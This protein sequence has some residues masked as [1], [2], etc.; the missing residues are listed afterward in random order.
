MRARDK[1]GAFARPLTWHPVPRGYAHPSFPEARVQSLAVG[2]PPLTH[3]S[4][5]RAS[6][7]SAYQYSENWCR[8]TKRVLTLK[9]SFCWFTLILLHGSRELWHCQVSHRSKTLFIGAVPLC[10]SHFGNAYGYF[11]F[12][13]V[14]M[15]G[16][17]YWL[18]MGMGWV[19]DVL[20]SWVYLQIMAVPHPVWLVLLVIHSCR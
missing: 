7:R 10:R 9:V 4:L 15:T 11:F 16:G 13:N 5:L 14:F 17:Y 6:R 12:F 2:S 8:D 18:P 3:C 20:L 1:S 19:T